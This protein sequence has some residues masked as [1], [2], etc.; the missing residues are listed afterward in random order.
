MIILAINLYM[1]IR[2]MGK[3]Y[4]EIGPLGI[5]DNGL[6]LARM[7]E[8]RSVKI[9]RSR[10]IIECKDRTEGINVFDVTRE[11]RAALIS[12]IQNQLTIR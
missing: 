8:C 2:S 1:N 12:G 7:D 3:S 10:L 11:S 5:K 4:I 9:E 6:L